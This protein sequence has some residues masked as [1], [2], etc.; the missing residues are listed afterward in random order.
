MTFH[1]LK[2]PS[3]SSAG[4]E[5]QPVFQWEQT[6][7]TVGDVI[8]AAWA[9]G[10]LE[11]PLANLLRAV[12]CERQATAQG[13][14]AED[15]SLQAMSEEFRYARDLVTVE[16]TERWLAARNLTHE[17]FNHYFLR[18][19]WAQNL[20]TEI[21]PPTADW[22]GDP[23]WRERLRVELLLSG[24]L[25]ALARA[26]V[27]RVAAAQEISDDVPPDVEMEK[28]FYA[29]SG[30]D[31]SALAARLEALNRPRAWLT[32]QLRL[33][34]AHQQL[35]ERWL[36][37]EPR[38]AMLAS[39]R[40]NLTR[41]EVEYMN[42]PARDAAQEALWC[43]REGGMTMDE[44]AAE[45]GSPAER[46]AVFLEDL[47]EDQQRKFLSAAPGEILELEEVDAGFQLCRLAGK[48]PPRLTDEEIAARIDRRILDK[49]FAALTAKPLR[50]LLGEPT[51]P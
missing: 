24:E 32:E 4:R 14:A 45:C 37:A 38:A 5:A 21:P 19:Y 35:C 51:K 8:H 25:D 26:L 1:V 2:S 36:T 17:D 11:Q 28:A 31:E 16:E 27:R 3:G 29:R 12:E 44:L 46:A 48:S 18:G 13:L 23:D 49:Q 15:A 47:T 34:A 41:L 43:L 22:P 20:E 42:L 50:W 39:Q 40:L 6:I 10:A 9:R 33:E 30:P 7:F